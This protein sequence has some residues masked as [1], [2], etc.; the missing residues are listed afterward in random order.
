MKFMNTAVRVLQLA[1]QTVATLREGANLKPC[2]NGLHSATRM[3]EEGIMSNRFKE[4]K[5]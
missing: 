3:H 2:Q 1:E 4:L 5:R